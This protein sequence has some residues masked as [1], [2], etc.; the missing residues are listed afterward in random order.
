MKQLILGPW[1]ALWLAIPLHGQSDT[2]LPDTATLLAAGDVAMC[3]PDQARD[4]ATARLLQ[5]YPDARVAALGDLAY[6]TGTAQD[7]ACFHASWGQVKDRIWPTPGNHEYYGGNIFRYFDY[8]NGLGNDSGPA[9]KRARGYYWREYGDWLLLFVN[10]EYMVGTGTDNQRLTA[11]IAAQAPWVTKVM[12]DHPHLC[13]MMLMH[14]TLFSSGVGGISNYTRKV[15]E[16]FYAG[17]G[18]VVI[19]GHVHMK[20]LMRKINVQGLQDPQG[21]RQFVSGRGG[22]LEANPWVNPPPA[23]ELWRSDEPGVV[24]LDLAPDGYRWTFLDTLNV[25]ENTGQTVCHD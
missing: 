23:Y 22:K 11:G 9:G 25:A 7:W 19:G 12:A 4:E 18:D 15:Y 13:Q 10:S 1:L 20:G 3:D 5:L 16:A 2:V 24:K 8:F 6:E 17:G 14:R 21:F